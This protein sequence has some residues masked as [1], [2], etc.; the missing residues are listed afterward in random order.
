MAQS[1]DSNLDANNQVYST[2]AV[3][4]ATGRPKNYAD[5]KL[6]TVLQQDWDNYKDD[7]LPVEQD[8]IKKASDTGRGS[9]AGLEA[10]QTAGTAFQNS[11]GSFTRGLSRAGVDLTDAQSAKIADSRA[12]DAAL[13]KVTAANT[14]RRTVTDQNTAAQQGLLEAGQELRGNAIQGLSAAAG[15]ESQRNATGSMLDG[16]QRQSQMSTIGTMAGM[17]AV[18]TFA[19]MGAAAGPMGMAVGAGI[20]L[21]ASLF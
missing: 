1:D 9:A 10:A 8:L 17:G 3:A 2:P 12:R 15:M 5:Q 18:G 19:G 11:E 13:T 21:L 16:Q 6:A 4:A 14:T 7:F 20:G